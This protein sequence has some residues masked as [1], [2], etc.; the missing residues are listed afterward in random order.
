MSDCSSVDAKRQGTPTSSRGKSLGLRL[1]LTLWVFQ[2]KLGLR[3]H[4]WTFAHHSSLVEN[5]RTI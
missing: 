1:F 2:L 5:I 4:E 3:L